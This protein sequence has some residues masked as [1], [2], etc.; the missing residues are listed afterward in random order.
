MI[1]I[2]ST[3]L[4][5]CEKCEKQFDKPEAVV[6]TELNHVNGTLYP[7]M[8]LCHVKVHNIPGFR[9]N[10]WADRL[11]MWH[12]ECFPGLATNGRVFIGKTTVTADTVKEM[13]TNTLDTGDQH[14][15][16]LY[17]HH[18]LGHRV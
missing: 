11:T 1:K 13:I 8:I 15:V 9:S 17:L 6:V 4:A 14:K 18:S 10:D 7:D 16:Y 3:H 12:T 2:N 5:I